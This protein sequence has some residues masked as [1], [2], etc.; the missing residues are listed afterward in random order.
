MKNIFAWLFE[1]LFDRLTAYM[2]RQGFILY[3]GGGG[4]PTTS[5]QY[6]SNIPEYAQGPFMDLVGRTQAL[7]EAPYT[8]FTGQRI[9]GFDPM[10]QRSFQQAGGLAG[11][12]F[13][14]PGMTSAFMS[15]F[16]QN[17]VD[18]QKREAMRDADIATTQRNAQAVK[19]GA[20]GGSRQAIMDAEAGRNLQTQLGDIQAKGLQSAYESGRN[21]FNTE[22]GQ[23]MDTTQLLNTLGGQ[24]QALGQRQLDQ[25]YSDFQAQRDYP[26]QQLGFLS[27]ILRG[28]SG[29][30]R[31][32]YS[33]NP[34]PSGLQTLA[35]LGTAA[36]GFGKIF[37]EGGEVSYSDGGITGILSDQQLQQQTQKPGMMGMAAQQEAVDRAA[38]RS[39][40]PAGLPDQG[41]EA[42]ITKEDLVMLLEDALQNGDEQ[43]AIA[44]SEVLDE[45]AATGQETLDLGIAAAAPQEMDFAEGGIVGY[46]SGDEVRI[47]GRNRY[48]PYSQ[49]PQDAEVWFEQ[50]RRHHDPSKALAPVLPVE[51]GN[52]GRRTPNWGPMEASEAAPAVV[53][54]PD[55][56]APSSAGSIGAGVSTGR[57]TSG[58]GALVP[59]LGA[60]AATAEY[61]RRREELLGAEQQALD[62]EEA[63]MLQRQKDAGRAAEGKETRLKG[64]QEGMAGKEADA[65]N[66]ALIQAGLA[67]LSADPSQGAFSA[68][69]SGALKGVESYKGDMGKLQE[70]RDKINSE[71]DD[72]IELRRQESMSQGKEREALKARRSQLV[73]GAKRDATEFWKDTGLQLKTKQAELT[74]QAALKQRELEQEARLAAARTAAG[75]RTPAEIQLIERIAAERK[76]PFSEAYKFVQGMKREPV[77]RQA[78]AKQWTDI[79]SDP[80]EWATFR[81]NNPGITSFEQYYATFSGESAPAS[82][83][84]RLKF[85]AQGNPIK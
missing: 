63:A 75:E 52:E 76:I 12:S 33:S 9:Q 50:T 66:M 49:R 45:M 27:D 16:M 61:G 18:V 10:Q 25:Q 60:D 26:Y 29:S 46:A 34:Q 19:A 4:G 28:V 83:N 48:T 72:I 17:V 23:Q 5:T 21:Q 43:T 84:T 1:G 67:I 71:L 80:V 41:G 69:G 38:L 32:M 79:R 51:Y 64:E 56:M 39:A 37:N 22:F 30:T 55:Q 14:Q 20:F 74:F 11:T 8:P 53:A 78:A 40:A 68:I 58:I 77:S 36:A 81:R 35:G 31:T 85:D 2:G 7:S 42:P 6:T 13:T 44:I 3:G 65:K 59:D 54:A 82:G 15:P 62:E 47:P 24:Q 70:R 57:A 73:V